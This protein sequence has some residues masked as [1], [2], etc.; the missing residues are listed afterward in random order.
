M[1]YRGGREKGREE[2]VGGGGE[3]SGVSGVSEGAGGEGHAADGVIQYR[4][5]EEGPKMAD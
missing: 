4:W 1:I 5:V 2:E 3:I